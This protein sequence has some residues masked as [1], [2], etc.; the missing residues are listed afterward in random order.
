MFKQ[1]SIVITASFLVIYFQHEVAFLL[2]YVGWAHH[3][4]AHLLSYVIAGGEVGMLIRHM[5]TL[6]F[7]PVIIGFIPGGVYWFIKRQ[8]MPYLFHIIWVVWL[9]LMSSMI[10]HRAL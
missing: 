9:I 7:V 4:I 1:L 5:L 2:G 10:L 8:Q 3:Y 6:F